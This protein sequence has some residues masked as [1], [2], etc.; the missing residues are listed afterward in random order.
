MARFSGS[1]VLPGLIDMHVH[2]PYAPDQPLFALLF[3]AHGV[4]TVRDTG[5]FDG[6]IWTMRQAIT[7]GTYPGP[8][9]FACGPLLDGEPPLWPGSRVVQDTADAQRA[10]AE[11]VAEG[12]DCVKVYSNLAP[13]G[14]AAIEAAAAAHQLPVIDHV[15]VA[16]PFEAAHL[17]DVQ[18]LTGV[19]PRVASRA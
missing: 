5:N 8:R 7:A 18:H 4:T 3:L 13:E 11:R 6:Q 19:L 12:A 15:P 10:V 14:L 2:F 16:V 1:Y 9:I 17:A